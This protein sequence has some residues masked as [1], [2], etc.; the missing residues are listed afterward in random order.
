[1]ILVDT[2]VWVDH[3]RRS[4]RHLVEVLNAGVALSHPYVVGELAC[5]QIGNRSEVLELMQSLPTPRLASIEELLPFIDR[6]KLGGRG[7]GFVDVSLLA[8][9]ALEKVPLWTLDRRLKQLAQD[10]E[11][12]YQV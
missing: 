12:A 8:S 9:A 11:L 7:V 5:G 6:H 1:M 4:N 10:L 3:L 2:S